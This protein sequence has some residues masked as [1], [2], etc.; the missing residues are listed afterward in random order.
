MSTAH[1]A[2]IFHCGYLFVDSTEI[3]TL[4]AYPGRRGYAAFRPH[5]L[6]GDDLFYQSS[7]HMC[8]EVLP[9]GDDLFYQLCKLQATRAQR[10][11]LRETTCFIKG[12]DK[13][14]SFCKYLKISSLLTE[15]TSKRTGD[16]CRYGLS[17]Q[18]QNSKHS[19]ANRRAKKLLIDLCSNGSRTP[20][21]SDCRINY[22]DSWPPARNNP[23]SFEIAALGS[24]STIR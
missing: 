20:R 2:S 4:V 9:Q 1:S 14:K 12:F 11:F 5:V 10:P 6:L 17:C 8:S 21:L 13:V 23:L 19:C 15:S 16:P 3:L 18:K 22:V 24:H 7:G